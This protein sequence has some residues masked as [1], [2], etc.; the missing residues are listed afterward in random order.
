MVAPRLDDP[1]TADQLRALLDYDPKLGSFFWRAREPLRQYD[2]TWNTRY[3]GMAAGTPTVPS[4]YVQILI[5]KRLY[6]GHRLAYLWMVGEW[7]EDEVDHIDR[8]PSNNRWANLRPATS[9]QGKMNRGMHSNNVSGFKGVHFEKRR[10]HWIATIYAQGKRHQLGSF[11][12]AD[13]AK[14]ARDEAARRLHGA[15]ARTD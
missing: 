4:G 1:L 5:N 10:S 14:A 15:F 12:T 11:P 3:A 2:R 9:S 6:L 8:D 7:P 13:L